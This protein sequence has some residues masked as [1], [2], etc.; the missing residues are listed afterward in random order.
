[1]NLYNRNLQ[2]KI[3]HHFIKKRLLIFQ[4][5]L[6]FHV[7]DANPDALIDA[8]IERINFVNQYGVMDN[9][10]SLYIDALKNIS[11]KYSD[12]PASAQASFLIAQTIYNNASQAY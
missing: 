7:N 4:N 8:D 11:E 5:L 9:K 6:E 1:M 2:R 10:D 3:L 12:N